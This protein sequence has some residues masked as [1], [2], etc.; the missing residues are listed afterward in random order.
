MFDLVAIKSNF[1]K[2]KF[3]FDRQD[4]LNSYRDN[5]PLTNV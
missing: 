5:L 4:E 1:E 3:I 2:F